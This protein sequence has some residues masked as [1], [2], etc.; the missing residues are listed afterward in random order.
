MEALESIINKILEKKELKGV[1][2]ETVRSFLNSYMKKHSMTESKIQ[3]LTENGKK[4]IIKDARA[5]LR[6]LVGRFHLKESKRKG[7][8]IKK[9]WPD[10]LKTHTSTKERLEFYPKLKEYIYSLNPA[11]IL[12]LGC[13]LNPIAIAEPS[14]TYYASDINNSDLDAVREYFKSRGIK[15]KV[16]FYDI[17]LS[18][19]DLPKADVVLMLKLVD[20]LEKIS[21][22]LTERL[23]SSLEFKHLIVSFSTRK[24]SG[25]RMGSPDRKLFENLCKYNNYSF[26]KLEFDN[27]IFYHV[28][29]KD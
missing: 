25:K 19:K 1:S 9:S 24:L 11:S 12:D 8:L 13:G 17:T 2:E 22:K 21:P 15:G 27:E 10:L 29:A 3:A 16:F 6:N 14:V 20:F 5:H 23:L 7:F 28:Q 4:V 18:Q 26:T